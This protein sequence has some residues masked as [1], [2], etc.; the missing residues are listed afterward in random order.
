MVQ[1]LE[2]LTCSGAD[3]EGVACSHSSTSS[4]PLP[5]QEALN[6][7]SHS[8]PSETKAHVFKHHCG[9][10]AGLCESRHHDW[11]GRS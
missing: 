4:I 5:H 7:D 2:Y 11:P 8:G 10:P 3:A 1:N 6:R 9:V